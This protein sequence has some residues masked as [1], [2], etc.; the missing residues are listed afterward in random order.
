MTAPHYTSTK[1][2]PKDPAREKRS[3]I[4]QD[5]PLIYKFGKQE[6]SSGSMPLGLLEA[7]LC[8]G[9]EDV[10]LR[11]I[12]ESLAEKGKL[13]NGHIELKCL[14]FT[15]KMVNVPDYVE[16]QGHKWLKKDLDEHG[17]ARCLKCNVRHDYFITI[18]KN[19]RR[20]APCQ[21]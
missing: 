5:K 10:T 20:L 2:K 12:A 4:E 16:H 15:Y 21:K 6:G 17:N 9:M 19:R 8:K 13:K 1:E 18:P 14:M 3:V 7:E 11:D